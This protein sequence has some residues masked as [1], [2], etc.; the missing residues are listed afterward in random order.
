MVVD[1][2]RQHEDPAK[3]W[4]IVQQSISL[5]NQYISQFRRWIFVDGVIQHLFFQLSLGEFHGSHN[6]SKLTY[7]MRSQSVSERR[8][9]LAFC[10]YVPQR[11]VM[12]DNPWST[13]FVAW[14]RQY[15]G[16]PR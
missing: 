7:I 3:R 12:A 15:L 8:A 6:S 5:Q 16:W 13:T 10:G 9:G 11:V 4:F 1:S 2:H 14:L